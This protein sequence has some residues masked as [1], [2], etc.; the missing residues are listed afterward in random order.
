VVPSNRAHRQGK[1]AWPTIKET[2]INQIAYQ[3]PCEIRHKQTL[4]LILYEDPRTACYRLIEIA[5]LEEEK[6]KK[7]ESPRHQLAKMV[8]AAQMANACHMQQD[9]AHDAQAT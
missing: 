7:E 9:H 1:H 5:R 2:K 4:A 3:S 6:G 8:L